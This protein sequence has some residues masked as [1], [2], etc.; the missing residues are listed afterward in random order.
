[1][2]FDNDY[3]RLTAIARRIARRVRVAAPGGRYQH[4]ATAAISRIA[5]LLDFGGTRPSEAKGC[6]E[7]LSNLHTWRYHCTV[8]A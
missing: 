2:M 5:T 7:G 3:G 6:I 8:S 1:M 4:A